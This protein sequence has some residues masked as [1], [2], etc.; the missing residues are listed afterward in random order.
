MLNNIYS[1]YC[2]GQNILYLAENAIYVI[3]RIYVTGHTK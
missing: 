2:A 1:M 3:L